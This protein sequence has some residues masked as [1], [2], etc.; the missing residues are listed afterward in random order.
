[1]FIVGF[2]CNRK[3]LRV[4]RLFFWKVLAL[5]TLQL[6]LQARGCTQKLGHYAD[7]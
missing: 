1:M 7:L 5:H 6:E 3:V 4:W 2:S